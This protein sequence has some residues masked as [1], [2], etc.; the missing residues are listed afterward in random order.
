[1]VQGFKSEWLERKK[2]LNE[3]DDEKI[4]GWL[5]E[6]EKNRT[7]NLVDELERQ[8]ASIK[9]LKSNLSEKEEDIRK[10]LRK[11]LEGN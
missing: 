1:M 11:I 8:L 4:A 3:G 2:R 6:Y 9:Q 7:Q 10:R 5:S